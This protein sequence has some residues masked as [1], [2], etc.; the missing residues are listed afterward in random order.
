M[1]A[2]A[3][4]PRP[5]RPAFGSRDALLIAGGVL[6]ATGAIVLFIRKGTDWADFPLLLVVGVPFVLLYGLGVSGR[7]STELEPWRVALIVIGIVLAPLALAQLRD[8]LGLSDDSSFWIFVIFG[9]TAALAGHA[10]FVVGSA[11]AAFLM[12]VAG[13]VA[14]LALWDWIL[15][16]PGTNTLRWLL[17]VI[18]VAY[19]ALAYSLRGGAP[20]EPEVVTAAGIAGVVACVIGVAESGIQA[21]VGVGVVPGGGE[22]Q[23]V[24]WDALLLLISLALVA[25][26][27]LRP[28][29][30]P[31]Y[32]GF[33]G[34]LAFALITGAQVSSLIEGDEP[35]QSIVGWPL[36]LLLA[37]GA[38]LAVGAGAAGA[39]SRSR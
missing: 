12:A 31:A 8:T 21:V 32:V 23:S 3:T 2:S 10:S 35:D 6:F 39:R 34:L 14:W 16:D 19:L 30:G 5:A 24:F 17:I 13:L 38:A 25:Y 36:L 7:S 29:R 4:T 20:Q 26:A 18:G 11:Y 33:A 22:G 9:L 1:E 37:G 15:D 28:A 27:A